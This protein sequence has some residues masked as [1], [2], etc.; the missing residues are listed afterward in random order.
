MS[1]QKPEKESGVSL[2]QS[3]RRWVGT[4]HATGNAITRINSSSPTAY[5]TSFF[6]RIQTMPS[7]VGGAGSG[8]L[9][10]CDEYDASRGMYSTPVTCDDKAEQKI[11]SKYGVHKDRE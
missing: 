11:S 7:D 4:T 5:A 3:R 10:H 6:L 2:E 1:C 8:F 9:S